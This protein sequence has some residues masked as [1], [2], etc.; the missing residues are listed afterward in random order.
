MKKV[1][2]FGKI[3]D[4]P[5]VAIFEDD[6]L[7]EFHME[8]LEE[9]LTG[10]I[11]VGRIENVVSNLH[12]FFVNIGRGKNGF[13]RLK[14]ST[15]I[16]TPLKVG[17]KIL[18]QV[19][20]DP[21]GSKGAQLTMKIGIPGRYIVY[22]PFS[23]KRIAISRR[24]EDQLE[25]KR[26]KKMMRKILTRDEG[27]IIRTAAE[28]ME[29]E[30]LSEELDKLRNL[31]RK[32]YS[33]YRKA[34]KP[35][36]LYVEP[37]IFEYMMR[38]RFDSHVSKIVVEK[39]EELERI[40]RI[41]ETFE[42]ED[43]GIEYELVGSDPFERYDV[44]RKLERSLRRVQDLNCGGSVVIDS[45][46][47]MT[48][49]DVNSGGNVSGE[50]FEDLALKT[51]M[52][53]AE[54]I[55]R[56]IRLRNVGGIIIVDFID[57]KREESRK[58]LLS[59]LSEELKKDKGRTS[60]VGFTKLGLLEMTRKRTS[61]PLVNVVF[62]RCPVCGGKGFVPSKIYIISKLK[63]DLIKLKEDGIKEVVIRFHESFESFMTK[64]RRK[65]IKAGVGKLKLSFSFD[66]HDPTGYHL[67]V[68]G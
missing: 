57:M 14:D 50:D 18:V 6:V 15:D 55:V 1:M 54:E 23:M 9:S 40:K 66:H 51:N 34:R 30:K 32:I 22:F 26:L 11:F 42:G 29:V 7:V 35:K 44:L 39:A 19:K 8:R 67:E 64:K 16:F 53:A 47:A 62:S 68:K 20:K 12:A 4:D 52:E 24:I 25:R 13:L 28:G 41:V 60:I 65:E 33:S 10:S 5:A 56:Q 27:V 58:K 48:V 46:E 37:D 63:K 45:T 2:I 31:W 61:V 49:I 43:S 3:A 21:V 38:E 36:V 17:S 59:Y